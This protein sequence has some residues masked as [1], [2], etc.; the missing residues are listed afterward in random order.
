[1]M[2]KV[3]VLA[4]CFE[5]N[6]LQRDPVPQGPLVCQRCN[7]S[8]GE[9]KRK[10]TK[11]AALSGMNICCC[12]CLWQACLPMR[13]CN[14]MLLSTIDIGGGEIAQSLASLLASLS[15]KRAIRVRA[16]LDPLVTVKGGI[17]SLCYS[18]VPT[19]ADNWLKKGRPCVIMS[20]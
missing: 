4:L 15:T 19:S 18:L 17:L 1:M 16:H 14:V 13:T 12:R 5:E 9:L 7:M 3:K 8:H 2:P 6:V 20:V 10:D 11:H